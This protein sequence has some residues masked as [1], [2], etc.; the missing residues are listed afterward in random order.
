MSLALSS[1]TVADAMRDGP[2]ARA[3]RRVLMLTNIYPD[4]V[5]PYWGPFVHSAV[6]GLRRAGLE[7][8]VMV[9]RGYAGRQEYLKGALRAVA[10]NARPRYDIVHANYGTMGIVGRLQL[11]TPL[12]IAY[13]GGDVLGGRTGSGR[14]PL[15]ARLEAGTYRNASRLAAAT[16]TKSEAMAQ[17]LPAKCRARNHVIPDGVDLA[18][19]GKLSREEARA[20]L[21][22]PADQPTVIFVAH[23]KRTVKNFPLAKAAVERLRARVPTVQLRVAAEIAPEEVP[24]WM[25]AADALVLTSRSEGSPNVIREAMA[26]ELPAVATPVGDVPER[27]HG[28]P[29]CHVCDAD[30]GA[31]ADGLAA[32]LAH[33]RTPAAR[34]AVEHV[35]LE[36]T[37]E[38]VIGVYE[39][40]L[41]RRAGPRGSR[42]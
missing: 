32:A 19:F 34:R 3:V 30:P 10:L 39:W 21:G 2:P 16:I 36:R 41:G 26:A 23:P 31:L 5:R 40:V 11:R 17:V 18:R 14:V 29:G 42:R 28:V 37:T 22:W 24:I 35:S 15:S 4:E 33:G 13:T 7:V 12:V 27:L 20:R 38:Q 9:V 6:E 8:D 1:P 25:A